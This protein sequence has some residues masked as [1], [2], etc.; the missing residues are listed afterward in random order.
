[1]LRRFISL[2]SYVLLGVAIISATIILVAVGEGYSYDF[3][4][5][6]FV[7]NGL[8]VIDTAPVS[9]T[10]YI[11]GK[12]THHSA[13]YRTTLRSGEY[14]VEIQHD[15]YTTWR[16]HVL[17]QPSEV[18][19]L[20]AVLLIPTTLTSDPVAPA[21]NIA[22]LFPSL[23]RKHL[24]Y[25]ASDTDQAVWVVN[26][27]HKQATKVYVP[28][29]ATA[30]KPASTVTSVAWSADGSHL[31][32]AS[33]ATT[34]TTYLLVAA[35]GGPVTDISD[36]FKFNLA[37]IHFSNYDWHELY[38]ASPEGLR[39]LNVDAKTVSVPLADKVSAYSFAG[40]HIIYIQSTSLGQAVY[41]M[42]RSGNDKK[43]LVESIAES[44]SYD[45]SYANYR[46]RD[47]LA[48]VPKQ[49]TTATLY[50]D[51]Y[52]STPTSVVVSKSAD[53]V[54]FSDDGRYLAFYSSAGFGSYDIER[55]QLAL[56]SRSLGAISSFNWLDNYH[57]LLGVGDNVAI[58]EADGENVTNLVKIPTG[59]LVTTAG[60]PRHVATLGAVA[61]ANQLF[62]TDLKR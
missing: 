9:G 42:D 43:L 62:I 22:G 49:S 36:L 8:L 26:A 53:H 6:Q 44:D 32:L 37:G 61:G 10:V 35:S 27:D 54:L 45:L 25:V 21:A 19:D 23:D 24:A 28:P 18:T 48:I 40:D 52:G 20:S 17:I 15:G 33:T 31:L 13:P 56:S 39:K 58:A 57:V 11:D 55:T 51:I 16:K 50:L 4:T 3:R 7:L 29:V 2:F 60:D 1:M 34:G 14:D 46:G 59:T 38:W 12:T 47:L 41:S 5:N 30:D